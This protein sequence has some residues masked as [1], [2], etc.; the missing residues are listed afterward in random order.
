M[1]EAHTNNPD[2]PLRVSVVVPTR[3]NSSLLASCL[4]SLNNQDYPRSAFELIV[5]DGHSSDTTIEVAKA[6]GAKVLSEEYG[7]RGGACNI[8]AFAASGELIVFTDDDASVPEDWL[9]RIVQTIEKEEVDVLGGSDLP[10]TAQRE[11]FTETMYAMSSLG[12]TN[13][14]RDWEAAA[15]IKGVNSAYKLAMFRQHS[16]FDT[17]IKYGEETELNVRILRSG[18]RLLYDPEIVVLHRV[19]ETSMTSL[20][21]RAFK[22]CRA[23]VRVLMNKHVFASAV[24]DLGSP[25]AR[26]YYILLG[27]PLLVV[28]AVSTSVFAGPVVT[29]SLFALLYLLFGSLYTFLTWKA[30][31]RVVFSSILIL[32]I[33]VAVR[34]AGYV[35]G[36]ICLGLHHRHNRSLTRQKVL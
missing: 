21:K 18:G 34:W 32:P 12:R 30:T 28:L 26:S 6:Y 1:L 22:N 15:A 23:S 24:R 8:G 36:L 33:L 4:S 5:V 10:P 35:Y 19:Q 29:L 14:R 25:V 20:C 27:V 7:T 2:R 13:R 9:T 16:G 17:K 11:G 3:N 31:R